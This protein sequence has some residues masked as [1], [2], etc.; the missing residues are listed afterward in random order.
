M[1]HLPSIKLPTKSLQVTISNSS[2]TTQQ[3]FNSSNLQQFKS[4]TVHIFNSSNLQQFK[5]SNSSSS[6]Y[7]NS[8]NSSR[9]QALDALT[10]H[11]AE[12]LHTFL[13]RREQLFETDGTTLQEFRTTPC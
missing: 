12:A 10:E 2:T 11:L 5:S 13:S 7:R 9:L 8:S 4:T 3:H 6:S 1:T